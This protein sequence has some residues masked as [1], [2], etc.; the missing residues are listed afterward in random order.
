MD[1][2]GNG[3]FMFHLTSVHEDDKN[4]PSQTK[5]QSILRNQVIILSNEASTRF[6]FLTK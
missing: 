1:T 5:D 3:K 4:D 2:Y 6:S